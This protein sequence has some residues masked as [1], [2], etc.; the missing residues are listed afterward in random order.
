M[1]TSGLVDSGCLPMTAKRRQGAYIGKP[2][3]P[4][5]LTS[6]RFDLLSKV[7]GSVLIELWWPP[8]FFNGGDW[9]HNG[10]RGGPTTTSP[11]QIK[12]KVSHSS[13]IG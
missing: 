4:V 10:D 7:F 2:P 3:P 5:S 13:E 11:V 9:G 6:F 1:W 8:V 12:L